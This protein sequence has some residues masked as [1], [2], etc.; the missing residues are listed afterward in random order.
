MADEPLHPPFEATQVCAPLAVSFCLSA[1]PDGARTAISNL[2]RD[3][4]APVKRHERFGDLYVAAA[5]PLLEQMVLGRPGTAAL[6]MEGL[7][8]GLAW[9]VDLELVDS[10]DRAT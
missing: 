10:R 5:L 2:R 7:G 4:I 1:R 9:C 6:E 3:A 8:E